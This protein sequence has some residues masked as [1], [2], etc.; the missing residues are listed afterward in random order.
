MR[1]AGIPFALGLSATAPV[2]AALYFDQVGNYDG[3]FLAVA[4]FALLAVMLILLARPP[5]RMAASED[6]GAS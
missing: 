2:A 1:S 6:G 3:A 4:G 5:I